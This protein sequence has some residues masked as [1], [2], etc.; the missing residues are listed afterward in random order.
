MRGGIVIVFLALIRTLSE[1]FQLRHFSSL[2]LNLPD[3]LIVFTRALSGDRQTD[4]QK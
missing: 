3:L 2:S 4:N 1:P